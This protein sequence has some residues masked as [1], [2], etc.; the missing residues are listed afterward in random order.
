MCK[1]HTTDLFCNPFTTASMYSSIQMLLYTLALTSSLA[2]IL[3]HKL[4]K[5]ESCQFLDARPPRKTQMVQ[6]L[7]AIQWEDHLLC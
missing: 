3:S 4:S 1:P 6:A 2:M 7:I 5:V